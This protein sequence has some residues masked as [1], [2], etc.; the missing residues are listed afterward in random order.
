MLDLIGEMPSAIDGLPIPPWTTVSLHLAAFVLLHVFF[1][2]G[3]EKLRCEFA[4]T[5]QLVVAREFV[6]T[7][8][9]HFSP[10]LTIHTVHSIFF[11][12]FALIIHIHTFDI[13]IR[14]YV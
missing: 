12:L 10:T 5:L 2:E 11:L 1:T 7:L 8:F 9:L 14:V 3:A 13:H 4:T 6:D